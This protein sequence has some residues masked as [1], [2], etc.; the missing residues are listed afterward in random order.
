[1]A[2]QD[3][4]VS[5]QSEPEVR[6]T[7]TL[8]PKPRIN[9]ADD[10]DDD[11][12][13][14]GAAADRVLV[15]V[16][17]PQVE[18]VHS[19]RIDAGIRQYLV[20]FTDKSQA[21]CRWV[22][23]A[24]LLERE[25]N[26]K[27]KLRRFD[28]NFDA[29]K[30]DSF[31][32]QKTI[33]I[34]QEFSNVDRILDCSDIFSLIHPKRASDIRGKWGEG[35]IKVIRALA[36]FQINDTFYGTFYFELGSLYQMF[37]EFSEAIDFSV[38]NNRIHLDYYHKPMDFWKDL[39][40]VYN[41]VDRLRD[42]LNEKSDL[43]ELNDRM[44]QLTA[45]LYVDWLDSVKLEAAVFAAKMTQQGFSSD[46][47][48]GKTE[49]AN[50]SAENVQEVQTVVDL[51]DEFRRILKFPAKVGD[52]SF[53]RALENVEM[54]RR[55]LPRIVKEEKTSPE[56]VSPGGEQ[57][58]AIN[59]TN[60]TDHD[61][62]QN[63]SQKMQIEEPIAVEDDSVVEVDDQGR[64][65]DQP[66]MVV[67]EAA[68]ATT[69]AQAPTMNAIDVPTS[70]FPSP[71]DAKPPQ[72]PPI[73][74]PDPIAIPP[75]V[76][77]SLI[78]SIV[79][80]A[81]KKFAFVD[82]IINRTY[83][84]EFLRSVHQLPALPP[85]FN[86][87]PP[88]DWASDQ[89]LA[90]L[91]QNLELLYYV[92]WSGCSYLDATWERESDLVGFDFKIKDFKRHMRSIDRESRKIFSERL[93]AFE[94]YRQ[95][96]ED[97]RQMDRTPRSKINELKRVLFTYKDPKDI[98]QY[99]QKNQPIF[100]NERTLRS[101]QLESL[102]W[103]IEA[104]TKK[105]NVILADEMG[106]GKTIQAMA[107]LNHLISS[108]HQPGPYLVIAPLT[109]LSHW[110]RVFE[111][112]THLN[113]ILYYDPKG[114][115]GRGACQSFE[116]NHWDITMKGTIIK[117]NNMPKF[118]V[119]ITSFEV[120]T[121]DF[122]AVFRTVPFQH[123]IIDEAHKLKNKN[124]KIITILKQLVCKRFLLLTGTPIQN[125][126]TELWALLN[127]LEPEIF[128]DLQQF[129]Q[130][131]QTD[132]KMETIQRLQE[133]LK[134][135][136]LRRMKEDVESSIPPLTET[137]IDIELTADQ[138]IIYKTLYEKNKGTLQKGL[139][140]AGVSI[141]NNL[142]MQLRKCCN[143]P[144]TIPE[145]ADNLTQE[146]FTS[147]AYVEKLIS[148]SGKL[149]FLDK[150]LEKFKKEGK[151]VLIFSQFTE[152]LRLLEE[153]LSYKQIK[154]Y[155]IDGSTKARDRQTA[156]DKF[157]G[158]PSDFEVFLLSTKA[159]GVGINLTSASVVIIFD[160]DWNPQ[161]DIQAIAR[162][163]RIGQT[164]EVKVF[165][166]I[167]KKTYES[168]MFERASV[169][170]GLDQAIAFTKSYN[171]KVEVGSPEENAKRRPEEI[172][173][174]LRKGALG[175]INEANEQSSENPQFA[176]NIDDIIQNARTANYSIINKNYTLA[177]KQFVSDAKD[178]LLQIDDPDFWK[179]AFANQKTTIEKFEKEYQMLT[180]SDKIKKI[181]FQ[182]D[183]FLRISEEIYRYLSE[184][185]TNEGFSADTEI[186]M[187]ELLVQISDNNQFH[188]VFREFATQ[189]RTDFS[190]GGRR[191]KR[192]DEKTLN[193][194]LKLHGIDS[195][196]KKVNTP[197]N[198]A[199][200]KE[201]EKTDNGGAAGRSK[202]N[203]KPGRELSVD[204]GDSDPSDDKGD[205]GNDSD[206]FENEEERI[207]IN[208]RKERKLKQEEKHRICD[209]CGGK[210]NL[211]TCKGF[212]G[213][214]MHLP[215]LEMYIR[216]HNGP[217][218]NKPSNGQAGP[219]A[220]LPAINLLDLDDVCYYCHHSKAVC[221]GCKLESPFTREVYLQEQIGKEKL[222]SL[223][224]YKCSACAKFYH[225]KCMTLPVDRPAVPPKPDAKPKIAREDDP[226][227]KSIKEYRCAQHFCHQCGE[228]SQ[229]LYQCTQCP[230]GYHRKC[231][232]KRNKILA[233]H[234]MVCA[235]HVVKP[236]K[237]PK[238]PKPPK[239]ERRDRSARAGESVKAT[240]HAKT[241]GEDAP[242][243]ER[244]APRSGLEAPKSLRE[245]ERPR[246]RPRGGID[247]YP[248]ASASQKPERRKE[249]KDPAKKEEA[250]LAKRAKMDNA[251]KPE[252]Q[253]KKVKPSPP[254]NQQKILNFCKPFDYSMYRDVT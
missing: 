141:M 97:P 91:G 64:A 105:R 237:P 150:A 157:N 132:K 222:D 63:G 86:H 125:N 215:C 26:I 60:G 78:N 122:D 93:K 140:L 248:N 244:K 87:L 61:D 4:T 99:Q 35:L 158:S 94:S 181:E 177:K 207:S 117:N 252:K 183:F 170:L 15:R 65:F 201:A 233:G 163:H 11:G 211:V 156:I 160:S 88:I 40:N 120:F 212:C 98:V 219:D 81:K 146:C 214:L 68:P 133:T 76:A 38:I 53:E 121:Q 18:T 92:K 169:K 50:F 159:G 114:K 84:P 12:A 142:E 123:I 113:S 49:F 209:F 195:E 216:Q 110:K 238:L 56:S 52:D 185:V 70:P 166:L 31:S 153:Y 184:R 227:Y 232:S 29:E 5:K 27:T 138:K 193:A 171:D 2:G 167:S 151:K 126:L 66:P 109:T 54:L 14:S 239:S 127:F 240:D 137:I 254:S 204:A 187:C 192:I 205:S 24:E 43:H 176:Q 74:Q 20:R 235:A 103:M 62:H 36:C 147:D 119:L 155:K 191:L 242:K 95:I 100:K 80:F 33:G 69:P 152:V 179:K 175:L 23:E 57:N 198:V 148:S 46:V 246:D 72:H 135:Y 173:M 168:E 51:F 73:P 45:R 229:N 251:E 139:G 194:E 253:S 190:K 164:N 102:N 131:Y 217:T 112:W 104:W 47:E 213:R 108:E 16:L 245:M 172:E 22:S 231:M 55:S 77:A 59:G 9:L 71:E 174:L 19:R 96:L 79:E 228:L 220:K 226:K 234:K 165:R 128:S 130:D 144:F 8:R 6:P 241:G 189:L 118:S 136:L 250:K 186:H 106:L 236:E 203:G 206:L 39:E 230:F 249:S 41:T 25:P 1:M 17:N 34:D 180:Q 196:G 10:I 223:N 58:G 44:K 89:Q 129:L 162:A 83:W 134:P 28:T 82:S 149:I 115:S 13:D 37:S 143:H 178:E 221:F 21:N 243:S 161:N 111:D 218:E 7:R 199:N 75:E 188:K 208:Y 30:F 210:E 124:A 225:P 197:A 116:F 3:L 107:F 90:L 154:G 67:E 48:R 247:P 32:D 200:P 85:Y 182:K 224:L 42:Y 202:N 101:Y 145:I